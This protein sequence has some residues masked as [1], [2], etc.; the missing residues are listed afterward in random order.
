ML[1]NKFQ[2]K[3]AQIEILTNQ[4]ITLGKSAKG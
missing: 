2:Y 4:K 3:F 1:Y